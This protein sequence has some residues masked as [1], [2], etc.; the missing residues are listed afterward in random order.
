MKWEDML[1]SKITM[2]IHKGSTQLVIIESPVY[3]HFYFEHLPKV[4]GIKQLRL[5]KNH[6]PKYNHELK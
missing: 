2:K 1:M 5:I 4:C 6:I 3:L